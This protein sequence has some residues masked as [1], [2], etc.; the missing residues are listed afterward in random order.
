MID[1]QNERLVGYARVSTN[2]Q[3]LGLQID[4]LRAHGVK[5]GDLFCDKLSGA[6]ENRPGLVACIESLQPG[7]TL[8]V[9]RLDPLGKTRHSSFF[10]SIPWK[11]EIS[12]FFDGLF[13]QEHLK[14]ITFTFDVGLVIRHPRVRACSG[15][16]S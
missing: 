15:L 13:L 4:A 3:E 6:R 11:L 16:Q 12:D 14:V 10:F 7:D 9:W 2:A 8:V 5:K 1:T